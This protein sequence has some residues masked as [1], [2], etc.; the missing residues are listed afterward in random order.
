MQPC[1][2]TTSCHPCRQSTWSPSSCH[3][4]KRKR[5]HT[6]EDRKEAERTVS[7]KS[8]PCE[9]TECFVGWK[10]N[11]LNKSERKKRHVESQTSASHPLL[12][13][14]HP[15]F[16]EPLSLSSRFSS[17]LISFIGGNQSGQRD[18]ANNKQP[19]PQANRATTDKGEREAHRRN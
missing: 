8:E 10:D 2:W 12:S 13:P 17:P 3:P 6:M 14:S 1:P 15:L 16:S 19:S 11:F 18:T 7:R 4:S 9:D 5:E